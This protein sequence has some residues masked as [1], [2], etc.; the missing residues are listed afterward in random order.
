M[1]WDESAVST[2]TSQIFVI[3]TALVCY[4]ESGIPKMQAK[5]G[6]ALDN[7]RYFG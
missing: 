7:I 6:V 4:E 3:V 5:I 1:L 2:K